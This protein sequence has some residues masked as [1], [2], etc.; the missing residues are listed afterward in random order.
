MWIINKMVL[1]KGNGNIRK[2][3]ISLCHFVYHKSHIVWSEM[4]MRLGLL[5][6]VKNVG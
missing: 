1:T 5:P 2:K 3:K 4:E 6:Y